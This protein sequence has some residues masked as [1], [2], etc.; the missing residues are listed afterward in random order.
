MR[1][2]VSG[3]K[4]LGLTSDGMS[5]LDEQERILQA[6]VDICPGPD[7]K[8]VDVHVDLGDL[9][10]APRPGPEVTALALRYAVQ[11]ARAARINFFLTGN[12]DKPTRGD[13]NALLPLEALSNLHVAFSQPGIAFRM[14]EVMKVPQFKSVGMYTFLFLPHVSAWEAKRAG[15]ESPQEMMD[16][17]AALALEEG[18]PVIAFAHLEVP[19]SKRNE[20]DVHQ[21]DVGTAIPEV[22]LLD[23]RCLRV[24]AGHVHKGQEIGKVRVVGSALHV[25]FSEAS[26]LKGVVVS[27]LPV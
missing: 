8:G 11:M 18:R 5:R 26:D 7:G 22:L 23:D 10:D 21:R 3:D 13:S 4:H 14:P 15:W 27:D 9:F 25:D 19:G 20:W 12:H 2:L 17:Q 24:Y 6:I 16:S 1:L